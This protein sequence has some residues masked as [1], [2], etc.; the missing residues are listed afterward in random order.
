MSCRRSQ[1]ELAEVIFRMEAAEKLA[2]EK[3]ARAEALAEDLAR[4]KADIEAQHHVILGLQQ[5]KSAHFL[6]LETMDKR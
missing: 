4:Q 1:V 3:M 2:G 6:M 5:V